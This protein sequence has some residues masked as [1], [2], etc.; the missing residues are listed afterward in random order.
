MKSDEEGM[1]VDL[2]YLQTEATHGISSDQVKHNFFYVKLNDLGDDIIGE[3]SFGKVMKSSW[4]GVPCA[5]KVF[6][7]T[8]CNT[9]SFMKHMLRETQK[10]ALCLRH[11]NIVQFYG[12][13]DGNGC[14]ECPSI[15]MELLVSSLE[16]FL[17][18]RKEVRHKIPVKF[19]RAVLLDVCQAMVYL[20]NYKIIHRDLKCSNILLTSSL[21][22]KVSDFGTACIR[23]KD[24]LLTNNPGTYDINAP[25]TYKDEYGPE[26]DVFSYGC[27]IIQMM[28]HE[29]PVP[30]KQVE[31][32]EYQRRKHL[33]GGLE[34]VQYE[35]FPSLMKECLNDDPT[36][37][38]TF[39]NIQIRLSS[40]PRFTN[41][42][43]YNILS[44]SLE[45]STTTLQEGSFIRLKF[46]EYYQW[47]LAI[48]VCFI[49]ILSV[50]VL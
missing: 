37:R 34:L 30:L 8:S 32:N 22:A 46:P 41:S 5:V 19:K 24:G 13:W 43:R 7:K 16:S 31:M 26:V 14:N 15:V 9:E 44:A 27:A 3:G 10:W 36:D 38:P 12:L 40:K 50:T 47:L 2:G 4:D 28:T 25:E 48:L 35:E 42:D 18:K 20:H 49:C 6:N 45:N 33:L 21:V 29:F 23:E 17:E 1:S 39:T 11:P